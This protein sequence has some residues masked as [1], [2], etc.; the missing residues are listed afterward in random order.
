MRSLLYAW[1]V[2]FFLAPAASAFPLV[3]S[4]VR[5]VNADIYI[6]FEQSNLYD[7]TPNPCRGYPGCALGFS[8]SYTGGGGSVGPEIARSRLSIQGLDTAATLGDISQ[9]VLNAYSQGSPHY[10]GRKVF[11]YC[12]RYF[13]EGGS[14]SGDYIPGYPGCFYAPI[15]PT[16]CDIEESRLDYNF[17]IVP[18]NAINSREITR[19]ITATCSNDANVKLALIPAQSLVPIYPD[20]SLKAK[21]TINGSSNDDGT[22]MLLPAGQ[23]TSIPVSIALQASGTVAE[24]A[25]SRSIVLV[26]A[27][28]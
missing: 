24:G 8:F 10:L 18:S 23:R 12:F 4:E 14:F 15:S 9:Q 19:H 26:L 6:R 1:L 16:V 22:N 20:G 28:P 2:V 17:G 7:D 21:V 27:M 3:H 11:R 5:G 13:S 25:F